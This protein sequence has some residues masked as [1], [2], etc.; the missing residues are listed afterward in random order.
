MVQRVAES[1]SVEVSKLAVGWR[2]EVSTS[3]EM[4]MSVVAWL[5]GV[6]TSVV[7]WR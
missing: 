2:S 1:M 7:M 3:A 4:S 5:L 6:S